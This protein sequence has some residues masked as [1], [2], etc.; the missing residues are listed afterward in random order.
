MDIGQR[1]SSLMKERGVSRYKMSKD[2]GIP[3]T[4]LIK[5]LDGITKNPQINN[6][7]EIANYFDLSVTELTGQESHTGDFGDEIFDED[8]RMIAREYKNLSPKNKELLKNI[9]ESLN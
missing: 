2:S 4:T 8:T 9:I 6:L 7:Q 1:I 5:I 3:Y